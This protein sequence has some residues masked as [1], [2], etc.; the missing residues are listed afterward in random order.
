MLPYLRDKFGNPSSS[1]SLRC[2]AQGRIE[3]ARERVAALLGCEAGELI[4][5]AGNGIDNMVIKGVAASASKGSHI[6]TS[7]SNIGGA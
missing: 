7:G 4:F 5:T 3:E 6:I 1:Q 2:G